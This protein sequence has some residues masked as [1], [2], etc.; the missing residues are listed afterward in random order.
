V[1]WERTFTALVV[2]SSL[3]WGA[4]AQ[5]QAP[6]VEPPAPT[7]TAKGGKVFLGL[8]SGYALPFGALDQG[9]TL[10]DRFEGHVPI[11]LDVGYKVTQNVV[12]GLYGEYGFGI[13]K[14]QRSLPPALTCGN[15]LDCSGHV[16]RFGAQVQCQ[17]APGQSVNPWVGLGLGYEILGISAKGTAGPVA[18]EFGATYLGFEFA[19]FQTGVDLKVARGVGVGPFVSFSL[20]QYLDCSAEGHGV[21]ATCHRGSKR[22]HEWLTLG[23][24]SRSDTASAARRRSRTRR[25]TRS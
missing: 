9:S 2:V 15:G 25:G 12:L 21:L 11:W 6:T 8:R 19:N 16:I 5:E 13:I 17:V 18:I 20:G 3:A 22:F 1:T 14:D 23:G 10:S 4:H 24:R 7:P